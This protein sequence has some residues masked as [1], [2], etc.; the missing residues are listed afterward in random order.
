MICPR[1]G[2]DTSASDRCDA[3][4]TALHTLAG[5]EP[6]TQLPTTA[7][8]EAFTRDSGPRPRMAAGTAGQAGGPLV[9]GQTFGPRYQITRLLGAG[10]MGAVYQ[11]EDSELGVTVAIKVIRPDATADSTAAA[12][13]EQRF[14]RELLLAREVTHKNVVRIHD[15]GEIGGIKY[16]TMS[17]VD[18][19]NLASVLGRRGKLPVRE[20]LDIARQVASGLE[21]AHEAGVVHRD[22]KPANVMID[23]HGHALIMDFGIARLQATS[24]LADTADRLSGGTVAGTILGTLDY[25]APEQAEG[26][27][28]DHR[29][30]IYTFGLIVRDLLVGLRP[31]QNPFELLKERI[32]KGLPPLRSIDPAIPES[33]DRISSRCLMLDP[34][35]RYQSMAEV[36]AELG[37][38]DENGVVRKEPRRLKWWVAAAGLVLVS[39]VTGGV[40][41]FTRPTPPPR[42]HETVSVLIADFINKTGDPAFDGSLEQSL[43]IGIEGASFITSFP[44]RDALRAAR[45]IA[46]DATGIDEATARLVSRR[47]AVKVVLAGTIES[48]GSGYDVSVRLV[49]PG[50]GK[51]LASL[52]AKAS[53]KSEVL[54]AIGSLAGGVR[55]NLGETTTEMAKAGAAETFT[56]GSIDAMRAYARGQE[57]LNAGKYKDALQSLQEATDRDPRMGRAYSAMGAIYVNL[58]QMDRAE[59][60]F[61]LAMK[62]LDRM[63]EREKYRTMAT[64]YLG[65]AGNY[66]K[67]IENYEA[68][69]KSYP[70]DNVAYGNLAFAYVR[71]GNI[72]RAKEVAR[73]GLEIYPKNLLQR[74]NY[75]AYCVYAGDFDT[76]A[77]EAERVLKENPNYEFAYLP[78]ALSKAGKADLAGA[79]QAYDRLAGVSDTGR[80]LAMLG[81]AD[82]SVYSGLF[83]AAV[84]PLREGVG[85]DQKLANTG[86]LATK[87]VV[88]AEIALAR[89]AR[90]EAVAEAKKAVA[91]S[92]L[93][94]VIV[95]AA[96]V[97]VEAG[98]EA[99]A[100]DIIK[101]LDGRL[102]NQT[103]AYA[104][105]LEAAIALNARRPPEAIELAKSALKRQDMWLG[106][107]VLGRAYLEAGH[108]QE[109]L[110]EWEDCYKTRGEALD[111]FFADSPTVR[112]LPSM[113][114]W[115]GR[116]REAVGDK[117]GSATAYGQYVKIREGAAADPLLTDARRRMEAAR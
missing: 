99:A 51:E 83:D 46:P 98:S 6:V 20:A 8:S 68:L 27:E 102:Q 84:T 92:R 91:G 49:D 105:I 55:R 62:N 115:L 61:Q 52:R 21:A 85:F 2:R 117:A 70:A 44:R 112:S 114:Y 107:F 5:L 56:A 26:K 71:I 97:F 48:A 25:M 64:Y 58:K 17:Y 74:T 10:G 3:C 109:A 106:H 63:S 14:K 82:L 87:H 113:Y 73:L 81:V 111:L 15:L 12:L 54:Q 22:L 42:P 53:G 40:A 65:V 38:L 108:A 39:A 4:G 79:R 24:R 69:I 93:V 33:L 89:G 47:E 7:P 45:Q 77:Q 36:C 60:A 57:L 13:V 110:D 41:W 75:A 9:P 19:E 116:A 35:A 16:I 18:G 29:A 101:D 90:A 1:C 72:P 11:A 31:A 67:G 37:R 23:R 88:L 80:S 100:R 76:A 43:G 50:P 95:P 78:L 28:V 104:R 103:S 96:Q 34:V 66:E 30:D 32:G 86:E 94:N 59:A